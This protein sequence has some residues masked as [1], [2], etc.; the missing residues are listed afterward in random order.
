MTG[1]SKDSNNI[2]T[3]NNDGSLSTK[4]ITTKANIV[5]TI[6]IDK[7]LLTKGNGSKKEPYEMEE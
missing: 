3:Y 2:Y 7:E 5:P 1:V 6:S 4:K